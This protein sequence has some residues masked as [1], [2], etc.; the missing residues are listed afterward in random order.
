VK[1]RFIDRLD[2]KLNQLARLDSNELVSVDLQAMD[3]RASRS[4]WG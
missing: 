2:V 4:Q 1:G 3:T